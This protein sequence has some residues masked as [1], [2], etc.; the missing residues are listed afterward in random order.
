M[1][2]S[3]VTNPIEFLINTLFGLYILL[4]MLRFLLA[5]VRA[6]FYNPV[7]QFLVKVT[8]PVTA[9]AATHSTQRRETRYQRT[10]ADAGSANGVLYPDRAAA[11]WSSSQLVLC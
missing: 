4:V 1:G 11:R 5:V 6:D 2:S 3:Y 7:S 9:T 10:V 8:N